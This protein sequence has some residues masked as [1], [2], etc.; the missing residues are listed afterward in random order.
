MNDLRKLCLLGL[1]I[2][3]LAA[4]SPDP[5]ASTNEDLT[6]KSAVE[7]NLTIKSYVYVD[8]NAS[9]YSIESAVQRQI[10][11]A[12]GPLRIGKISVDDREFRNIDKST[13][14]KAPVQVIKKGANGEREVLKTVQKVAYSYTARALVEKSL[15]GQG[16]FGMALLMGNYQSIVDEIIRDCTENYEHDRDFAS[17]FWYVWAPNE[18]TCKKLIDKEVQDL[19]GAEAGLDEGQVSEKEYGRRYLPVAAELKAVAAPKTTYP[20]YDK[21]Y[22]TEDVSK[23]RIVVYQ[24]LGVASH[25]GDPEDQRF[26]NDMGFA[27]YFKLFKVISDRWASLKVAADSE[28]NPLSVTFKGKAYTGSWAQVYSWVVSKSSYPSDV[29]YEDQRAF[30]RAIHDSLL[31]KWVKLELP[32]TVTSGRGTKNM[33]IEFRLL[34]GTESGWNVRSYFKEAFK[35]GDVVMYDGHSY[36]GSGPLDPNNYSPADF[37]DRY[38]ILFFNSCVSFNY[39]GVSYFKHK[40]SAQLDLVTN[41]LEVWINDGGK[42]MGQFM[43]ALFDGKQSSW[44]TVLEKTAIKTGY[45]GTHDPNRNVDGELDNTY[46]P[47]S[48]PITV[49]EGNGAAPL[50]VTNT[51]AGCNQTVGGTVQLSA[52]SELATRVEFLAGGQSLGTDSSKPY[53]LSFDTRTVANGSVTITARATDAS[54]ATA[55]ASCT[56]NVSNTPAGNEPLFS[57]DMESAATATNWTATGLWHLA[58]QSTCANPGFASG[59]K[60]FYFGQ[61]AGCS[62]NT[63]KTVKGT[64]TSKEIAGITATSKLAFQ[65]LRDVESTSSG[66]YDKTSVEIAVGSSSTWKKIWSKDCKDASSKSWQSSGELSLAEYAGKTIKIRFNFDS[67]DSYD[68]NHVGW[69]VDDVVV[70]P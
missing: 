67:V 45:W 51:S 49:K 39:Y 4:C 21:L 14:V 34:F 25:D 28:A 68:N 24:I 57:D 66:S 32:I 31:L 18:Y 56:M 10:R 63:S 1:P 30:R 35:K 52:T 43:V 36:I 60:S 58:T 9:D 48:K 42:S 38:Q 62:Y 59:T 55:E 40:S 65:Y 16:S 53:A 19:K 8:Q 46:D 64:L 61:D 3:A 20:E 44:L 29:S 17:S 33:T 22:G 12:F 37:S 50:V 47:Q 5:E 11:T 27:E 7:K 54:G 23:D 15:D 26:E 70:T 41:G 6:S 2:A 13:F 69:M